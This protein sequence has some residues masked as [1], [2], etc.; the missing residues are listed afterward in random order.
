M[1]LLKGTVEPVY[2]RLQPFGQL[3]LLPCS[4]VSPPEKME[5]KMLVPSRAAV[6]IR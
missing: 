2:L 4:L 5:I 6:E 3:T 1:S